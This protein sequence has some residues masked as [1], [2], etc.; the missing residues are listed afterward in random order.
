MGDN[1]H[2][3]GLLEQ[4]L[5]WSLM[6]KERIFRQNRVWSGMKRE[7]KGHPWFD[8]PQN[9][10]WGTLYVGNGDFLVSRE[11]LHDKIFTSWCFH[12]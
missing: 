9:V 5:D 6:C 12:C 2:L 3:P 7:E 1:R 10:E 11:G 8:C 4:L